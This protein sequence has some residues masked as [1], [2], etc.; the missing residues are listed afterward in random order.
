MQPQREQLRHGRTYPRTQAG[1]RWARPRNEPDG[2]TQSPFSL[3]FILLAPGLHLLIESSLPGRYFVT[4]GSLNKSDGFLQD[5][6][7]ASSRDRPHA[8]ISQLRDPSPGFLWKES[9]MNIRNG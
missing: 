8:Q 2:L 3:I 7:L 9:K 4:G 5:P 6:E 1:D